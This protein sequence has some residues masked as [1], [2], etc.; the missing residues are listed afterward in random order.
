LTRAAGAGRLTGKE[1]APH[2]EDRRGS[3]GTERGRVPGRQAV[4]VDLATGKYTAHP[5]VKLGNY[6][7]NIAITTPLAADDREYIDRR[8]IE[9][10]PRGTVEP[11]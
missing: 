8:W 6:H 1:G 3:P 4:S 10:L 11:P 5:G 9:R 7:T 2:E